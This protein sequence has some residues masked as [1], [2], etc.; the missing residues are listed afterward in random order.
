MSFSEEGKQTTPGNPYP[1]EFSEGLAGHTRS[2]PVADPARFRRDW[3]HVFETITD[4][5]AI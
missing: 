1:P 5:R 4:F 3:P 2:C